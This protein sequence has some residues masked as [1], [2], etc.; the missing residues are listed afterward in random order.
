MLKYMVTINF[1]ILSGIVVATLLGYDEFFLEHRTG[2]HPERPARVNSIVNTLKDDGLWDKLVPVT[3]RV[4]PDAWIGLIHSDEY[5]ARLESACRSHLP[6]IDCPDSA[7]SSDSFEVARQAVAVTLA[8]CDAIIS[9]QADNGFCPLRPPGHHAEHDRSMGFCLFN[10]I[11]VAGRYLQKQHGLRRIL[12]LDWDVHHGNGT[13]HSFERDDS[14]F[15]ASLHQHPATLYPGT[16]WPN[17]RGEGPGKG[18]TLNLPLE[19][20]A[21]DE[22]C[23]EMFRTNFLPAARDFR[24]DFVLVSAGY[25]GHR[26]DPLAQLNMTEEGYNA[27]TREIKDFAEEYCGGR[28][29]SLLEGGYNLEALSS[30]VVGHVEVLL[31]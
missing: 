20:S 22:D 15:Y 8:A 4:E 19:P 17:E 21:T 24:P 14:V 3:G 16:G 27:M 13:Q 23:L 28:L 9:D 12:I 29:L 18:F 5:V 7:I 26:D 11:A 25:D 1:C 31:S 10:N 30:C 2:Q 6:F